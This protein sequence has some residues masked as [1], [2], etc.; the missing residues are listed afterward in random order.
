M[1]SFFGAAAM[2]LLGAVLIVLLQKY[3]RETALVLSIL[4]CCGLG[5]LA[6]NVLKP[7]LDFIGSL[8]QL[9]VLDG[10][11]LK[12]L[13][14]VVGVSLVGEIA[15]LLCADAGSSSLGKMLQYLAGVTVLWLSLPMLTTLLELVEEIL[16]SL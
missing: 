7:V 6:M 2:C 12:T 9:A 10:Q 5:L 4:V 16:G 14:K 3:G 13:L 1:G 11:L 15:A 8:E